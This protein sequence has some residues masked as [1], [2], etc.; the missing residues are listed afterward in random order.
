MGWASH[1]VSR[2]K[3]SPKEV[4]SREITDFL[5]HDPHNRR[6]SLIIL[7]KRRGRIPSI[8]QEKYR[9]Y[10]ASADLRWQPRDPAEPAFRART[11]LICFPGI[12]VRARILRLTDEI[13]GLLENPRHSQHNAE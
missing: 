9:Y 8:E 4:H 7:Q 11:A 10:S 6:H 3:R 5:F 12:A 2:T 1:T 13:P